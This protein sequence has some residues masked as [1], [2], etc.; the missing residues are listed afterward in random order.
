M[1]TVSNVSFSYGYDPVFEAV[2]F[3]VPNGKKVGLVGPN[4]AGKSTLFKLL[5]KQE[6]P[7]TGKIEMTGTLRPRK[8]ITHLFVLS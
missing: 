7:S 5:T 4:G 3:R 6:F 1:I 8:R 2:N